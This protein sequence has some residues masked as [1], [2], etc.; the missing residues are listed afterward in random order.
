MSLPSIGE[1]ED[2][3][4]LQKHNMDALRRIRSAVLSQEHTA[5]SRIRHEEMTKAGQVNNVASAH[6]RFRGN[7]RF[8]HP[9]TKKRRG[10]RFYFPSQISIFS[11]RGFDGQF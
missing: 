8:A 7:S 6:D 3:M 10:V 4:T 11:S 9:V 5:L 1:I 2:I